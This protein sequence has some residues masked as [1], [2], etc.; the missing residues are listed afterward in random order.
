[1]AHSD[2]QSSGPLLTAQDVSTRVGEILG[3]AEREAREMIAAARGEDAEPLAPVNPTLDD[4]ARAVERLSLRLD[5]FELDISAQID[6]LV[7]GLHAVLANGGVS[8]TAPDVPP[9][10]GAYDPVFSST[11]PLLPELEVTPELAAARVRAIDLALAG[12]TRE[13]IANELAVSFERADVDALL[14]RVLVG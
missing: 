10:S 1:M 12:Y 6:A 4:L 2:E 8:E 3:A 7:R 11:T 14:D 9:Q 13:A 5:A